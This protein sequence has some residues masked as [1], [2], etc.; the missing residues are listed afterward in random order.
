M[1]YPIFARPLLLVAL[2][3]GSAGAAPAADGP[4][5]PWADPIGVPPTYGNARPSLP[6]AEP[7]GASRLNSPQHVPRAPQVLRPV[8]ARSCHRVRDNRG[9]VVT[10]CRTIR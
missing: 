4:R 9:N 3:M 8:P 7:I 10:Y 2:V 6:Y 5:L 1:T